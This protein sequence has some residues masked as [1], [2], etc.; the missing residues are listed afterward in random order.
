MST[1][2]R[3]APKSRPAPMSATGLRDPSSAM[4]CR[5]TRAGRLD[6]LTRGEVAQL[7]EHTAENRGVAGSS[8]ALAIS[9]GCTGRCTAR[10]ARL[11]IPVRRRPRSRFGPFGT[12]AGVSWRGRAARRTRRSPRRRGAPSRPAGRG[13]RARARRRLRA[14]LRRRA[15]LGD[16]DGRPSSSASEVK[17][18][19]S[20]PQAVIQSAE[21]CRVEVDIEGVAVR[22]HPAADV[23]ADRGDLAPARR[24]RSRPD[25]GEPL[26]AGR[27][28]PEG[29]ERLD[30]R[31]LEVAAVA[32][33]VLAVPFQVEDRVADELP[34]R[35]VGGLAAAVGLDDLDVGAGAGCAA[36]PGRCAG[37]A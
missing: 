14:R 22:G 32:A 9:R 37:R 1:P 7:V 12:L 2:R 23:H 26:D 4:P 15:H 3:P 19:S 35:V 25:A 30:D 28:D 21:R 34:R 17:L 29:C 10:A 20:S 33:H 13:R 18:A 24:T 27:L 16:G 31:L 11:H 5:L 8:P 36:R 6:S